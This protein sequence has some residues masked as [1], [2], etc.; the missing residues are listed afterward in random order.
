MYTR[1]SSRSYRLFGS[2]RL[3]AELVALGVE[4]PPAVAAAEERVSILDQRRKETPVVDERRKVSVETLLDDPAADIGPLALAELA[5]DV[6]R[7]TLV[8]ASDGARAQV[9]NALLANADALVAS[10][11]A[12]VFAPALA[13]LVEAAAVAPQATVAGLL[14]SG[15]AKQARA[16]ADAP[17]AAEQL[18]RAYR[19]RGF[20]YRGSGIDH[21]A[22]ARWRHPELVHL[23]G[24]HGV[25]YWCA[26]IRQG[27]ELWLG[28]YTDVEA[29]SRAHATAQ[30]D[31]QKAA[32]EQYVRRRREPRDAA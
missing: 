30:H 11:D 13:Q 28:T 24:L 8:Q 22:C 14:Q 17:V 10:L 3:I 19:L 25:D 1:T 4:I 2:S 12:V 32:V 21:L 6:E 23:D 20:I 16:L 18:K 7:N 26:G 15:K 29:A 5:A 9:L 27:G 31:E